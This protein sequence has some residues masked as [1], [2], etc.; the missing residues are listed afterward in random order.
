M[1]GLKGVF[2]VSWSVACGRALRL[3]AGGMGRSFGG[4]GDGD[5]GLAYSFETGVV[6][7]GAFRRSCVWPFGY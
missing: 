6:D 2:C 4:G 5:Y 1:G 7:F 3:V